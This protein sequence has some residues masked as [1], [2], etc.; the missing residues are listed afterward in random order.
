[1]ETAYELESERVTGERWSEGGQRGW[2]SWF[3]G[4][5][6]GCV[7]SLPG[8]AFRSKIFRR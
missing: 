6:I 3:A 5:R 1:M 7:F 4:F 2:E 8:K